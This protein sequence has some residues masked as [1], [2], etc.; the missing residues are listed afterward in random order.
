MILASQKRIKD[1][2]NLKRKNKWANIEYK[3]RCQNVLCDCSWSATKGK[4]SKIKRRVQGR[5]P[6]LYAIGETSFERNIIYIS[7]ECKIVLFST[8][9]FIHYTYYINICNINA[10]K[11][12]ML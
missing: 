12:I 4:K 7:R 3:A 9:V 11:L 6:C 1:T 8:Y 5:M 10:F 2:I